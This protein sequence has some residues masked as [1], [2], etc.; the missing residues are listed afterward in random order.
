[1][2]STSAPMEIPDAFLSRELA[3]WL[4]YYRELGFTHLYR[5]QPR[6]LPPVEAKADI[7]SATPPNKNPEAPVRSTLP[8]PLRPLSHQQ[9]GLFAAIVPRETLDQVRDDLGD[10]RRC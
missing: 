4:Q 6:S 7:P 8:V 2:W 10:C 1:M 5:R 3:S 9:E